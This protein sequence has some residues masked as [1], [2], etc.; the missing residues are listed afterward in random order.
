MDFRKALQECCLLPHLVGE[1]KEAIIEEMV[2]LLDSAGR[3]PDRKAALDSVFER[4][5]QMSTGMQYGIAIPH[6]K[7]DSVPH[8]V[9]AVALKPEGV[10]FEALDGEPSKIFVMTLSP[11]SKAGSHIQYLSQISKL[12]NQPVLR[13]SLLNA[14]TEPEMAAVLIGT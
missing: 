11:V 10:D 3:L 2:D 5:S 14:K 6:G 12:L 1:T 13:D 9:T 7:T 8:L 4:E